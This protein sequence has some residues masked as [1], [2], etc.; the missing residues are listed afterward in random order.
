MELRQI[1]YFIE[2]ATRE[3][4]T[5]ASE[6]LHVA[7]SAISRQISLLEDELGVALFTRKGRNIQLTH[8]GKLFLRHAE[9][10]LSEFETA[11]QKIKEYLNPDSG[12]IRL[13]ISTSL[14]VH[15]LPVVLRDFH[16]THP[17]INFQLH[18]G[19]VPYLI[20]LIE[21][22]SIDLAFASPVPKQHES[23]RSSI[24]YTEQMVLLISKQHKKS[25]NASISLSQLKHER[26]ITFRSKLSLREL[27]L[28]A[29]KQAAFTPNIV[30]EGEDMDT[31][32]SL[33]ASNFGIALMPENA[34][35]YNLPDNV[36]VVQLSTPKL[37]RSVGII[38]P[39]DR[40]LAP[41][42]HIFSLFIDE[43][44]DRLYRFGQ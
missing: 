26:F 19:T 4:M 2:A 6:A 33:V 22:G 29:C 36:S 15:T 7:Q 21:Q 24:L 38:R 20:H 27:F 18:Q 11:Q 23:V 8:A 31:I 40:D 43:F 9:R 1:Q 13:G 17:G 34:A 42:E 44:Y 3:H 28:D 32:K 39:S 12:L 35:A 16:Q 30:F 37:T 5:Q 25:G 14:S 41:S 10:G